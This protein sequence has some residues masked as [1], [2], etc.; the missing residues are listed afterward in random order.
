VTYL[1]FGCARF[2]GLQKNC[3]VPG[4]CGL[5]GVF[6]Q[7]AVQRSFANAEHGGRTELVISRLAHSGQDRTFFEG[8]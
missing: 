4:A 5:E 6:L 2:C 3:E 7:L 1:S 8:R